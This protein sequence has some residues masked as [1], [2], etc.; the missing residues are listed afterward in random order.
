MGGVTLAIRPRPRAAAGVVLRSARSCILTTT[1][2]F[3]YA[4][5]RC[6]PR[7]LQDLALPRLRLHL[8]RG[9]GVAGGRNPARDAL[10]RHPRRLVLPG[11]RGAQGGLRNGGVLTAQF[12]SAHLFSKGLKSVILAVVS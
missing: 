5:L 11:V 9:R 10:G 7:C 12:H 6:T 3:A 1:P 4:S 8:R 2:A